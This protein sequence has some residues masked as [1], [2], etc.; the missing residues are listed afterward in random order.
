LFI[1]HKYNKLDVWS[2]RDIGH[3]DLDTQIRIEEDGKISIF[4]KRG[5][6]RMIFVELSFEQFFEEIENIAKKYNKN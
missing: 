3:K 4:S 1:Q 2:G 5:E 6:N